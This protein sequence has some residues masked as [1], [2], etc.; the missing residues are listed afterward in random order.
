MLNSVVDSHTVCAHVEGPKIFLGDAGV[1]SPPL[2]AD[3][4]KHD[5][6]A[7]D[8]FA[9]YLYIRTEVEVTAVCV[10]SC[11]RSSDENSS[12]CGRVER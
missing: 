1:P 6:V 12:E 2:L 11:I 7:P 5:A 9:V 10:A 3:R 4:Q 8:V